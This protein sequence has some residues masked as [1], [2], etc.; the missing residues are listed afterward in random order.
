ME[1]ERIME[2]KWAAIIFIHSGL[3]SEKCLEIARAILDSKGDKLKDDSRCSI[4]QGGYSC[5]GTS[6]LSCYRNPD[7][8]PKIRDLVERNNK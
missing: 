6:C 3:H 8:T 7:F 5:A 1:G 2:E 4:S